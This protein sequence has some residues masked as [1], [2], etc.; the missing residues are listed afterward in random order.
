VA[1]V[2]EAAHDPV[3]LPERHAEAREVGL[4]LGVEACRGLRQVALHGRRAGDDRPVALVLAVEDAQRV[5]LQPQPAVGRQRIA[6]R[7]EVG[8]Q[9]RAVGVAALGVAERVDLQHDAFG[10]AERAQD[11]PARRDH[12]GIGQRLGGAQDLGADLVELP[13]AALLRPLVAEHRAGIEHLARQVRL[14]Q[15]VRDQGAADAGGVLGAQRDRIAAA[16][17]EGIH[18]LRDDVGGVAEAAGEDAR[19]LEDRR[20]P[21]LEAIERGD[22]PRGVGDVVVPAEL[23]ADEVAGA[24]DGL[25]RAGHAGRVTR[26]AGRGKGRR[27]A[28]GAAAVTDPCP[29]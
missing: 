12:L 8:D 4:D 18:L 9:R 20:R 28:R 21:F 14:G 29:A 10:D 26:G 15:P 22:A 25:E 6:V 7:G 5:L 23:L 16:I 19:V 11:V 13:V 17:L 1:V 27:Q 2:V 3:V 24:T